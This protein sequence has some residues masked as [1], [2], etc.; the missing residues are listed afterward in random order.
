MDSHLEKLKQAVTGV[1]AGM[2]EQEL[3]WHP[4]G[5][6]S[7]AEVLEHL[8]LTY[9]RTAKGFARVIETGH[10]L[11]TAPTFAQRWRIFVVVGL[12]Y[13]PEGRQSPPEVRPRGTKPEVVVDEIG[14]RIVEMDEVM[15]RC[16]KKFGGG[17]VRV[18][19]HPVLG[20][21]T[22]GQWRKFHLVH[23]MHHV[24]QIRGLRERAER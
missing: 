13:F 23:G 1:V 16:E 17:G 11:A 24:K 7:A 18:L 15:G 14:T 12:G 10:S 21:L 6:W 9:S 20:A 2:S 4:E 5:K 8:Y 19:D 3:N 22:P